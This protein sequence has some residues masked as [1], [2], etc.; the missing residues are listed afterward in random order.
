[1]ALF[2]TELESER[3]RYEHLNPEA[4][5]PMELYQHVQAG[6]PHIDEITE[7]VTWDPH[8]HPRQTHDWVRQQGEA[9]EN[10]DG[11]TYVVRPKDGEH[12]GEFAGL[13][14]LGIDWDRQTAEL[15]IWLRK[16]FWGRG[17]SGERAGRLLELAFD[18]L[19]LEVVTV[20]H[21]PEND[22]S[23]KAIQAYVDRFGGQKEGRLRNDIVMNGEPRDSIRYS[24]AAEEWKENAD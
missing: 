7:Y 19:D 9:F 15:G 12:A 24:I 16:P 8:E 20:S 13:S 21:D 3:L 4:F 1:M 2:P 14:G 23:R 22:K 6:A 17:Y 5:D 10:G 11:V 18:H